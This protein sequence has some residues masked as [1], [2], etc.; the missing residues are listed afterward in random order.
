MRFEEAAAR[1]AIIPVRLPAPPP[2]LVP[3]QLDPAA[4]PWRG[5]G[6]ERDDRGEW[7]D[8]RRAVSGRD[9]APRD[10]APRDSAPRDLGRTGHRGRP[11]VAGGAEDEPAEWPDRV[12][13]RP[14]EPAARPGVAIDWPPGPRRYAAA[15]VLL[16]PDAEGE[17][18]VVLI[19]RPI[20]DFRH[21]G[22]IALPGGEI[23]SSDAHPA[24]AA[25]REAQEEVGIDPE[26]DEITLRGPLDTIEV[27]VSGFEMTPILALAPRRP[28]FRPD[29][30]EVR[31]IIE[32]P[33]SLFLAGVQ[34]AVI[35]EERRG[36][37]LRY[38]AYLADDLVIWGA[39]AR[40]LG[41]VGALLAP[42]RGRPFA[43]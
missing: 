31:R 18:R 37:R 2:D 19:E 17:T 43:G 14:D 32:V 6:Y 26:R 22:E 30:H 39:T 28:P 13:A 12:P 33:I 8:P 29:A 41:Q 40:A 27:R 3:L 5:G 16:Y 42:P 15:L 9:L 7:D 35:T 24:A 36:H 1:L 23:E 10:S 11:R 21:P 4:Q 20:G 25:L 34:L 38:G